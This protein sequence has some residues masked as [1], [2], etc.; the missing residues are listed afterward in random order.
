MG[1]PR[2]PTF[3]T[4]RIQTQPDKCSPR[5][6]FRRRRAR[7][8]LAPLTP[9][10]WL[11]LAVGQPFALICLTPLTSAKSAH[12]ASSCLDHLTAPCT[13][14]Q[15]K[16]LSLVAY[17]EI[18]AEPIFDR[19][20]ITLLVPAADC[21]VSSPHLPLPTSCRDLARA[22]FAAWQP[23]RRSTLPEQDDVGPLHGTGLWHVP[24][25]AAASA[26]Y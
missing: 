7:M 2:T 24:S 8:P 3:A 4:V 23:T 10:R 18:S 14:S 20:P 5:F 9:P 19:M 21:C 26:L 17:E 15:A 16:T 13:Q 11:S 1:P 25:F 12:P 6:L 22:A